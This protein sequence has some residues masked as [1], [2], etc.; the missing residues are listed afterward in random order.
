MRKKVFAVSMLATLMATTSAFA[1]DAAV[2]ARYSS[3]DTIWVLMGAFLVF[4]MQPGFAMVEAGLTR[5]KNAGNIVMKNFMDF[6]LGTIVFWVIGF[7]LMFGT[8]I[9]GFIG[10]PDFFA[11]NFSVP[12]EA[13][14]TPMAYLIFQTVFCATAATIVSG[15]MAERTKFSAYCIYSIVISALIYPISG[16]W[17]WGGGWL[18]ELGFHDFA[19]STVVH[20]V[21]GVSALVGAKILGPRIGKYN[22]DGSLNAIPG[23]SLTLAALG[24]FILWFGW[25]GFNGASTVSATG[26]DTLLSIS[27]IYITTN[28]AAAVGATV[29]MI[30]TWIRYG[31]P[32]VSMSL[33]GALAGLVAITA[34]TDAVNAFGAFAIGFIA[35]IVVVFSVEFFDKVVKIDDPVGAISVHGTCGALGTILTGVFALDGG[36]LYG[37]GTDMLVTQLIGVISIGIY[38]TICMTVVFYII[39]STIGLRVSASEELAGLDLEEHGLPS[40]YAD[41]MPSDLHTLM[42]DKTGLVTGIPTLQGMRLGIIPEESVPVE[43][44]IPTETVTVGDPAKTKLTLVSIVTAEARFEVLKEALETLGVTGMTVVRALGY[45]LERGQTEYYRGSVLKADLLPKVKVELVVSTIPVDSIVAAAKKAL[46]TGK[47]GDG[48]IFIYNVENV[49]KIRTGEE[50]VEALQDTPIKE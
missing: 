20:M 41:F 44:A 2:T 43:S 1:N 46:Y 49:I 29:V 47:Y 23:H 5:A 9:G 24:V 21:G 37:G 33:N 12:D 14:Y 7:G 16:H 4:F 50:G 13:G 31:K 10:A 3:L 25:F 45:G 40:A 19:G 26:D 36:L 32:D 6:A 15:A 34:G 28:L 39:K 22:K 35:G 38:V 18:T 11:L 17:A 30:L 42:D 48:K 8:D 27:N